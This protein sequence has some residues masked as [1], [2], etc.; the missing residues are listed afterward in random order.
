MEKDKYVPL[1]QLLFGTLTGT[2]IK[3]TTAPFERIKLLNQISGMNTKG[4]TP[5][6]NGFKSFKIIIQEEGFFSL[7]RG[8]LINILR[9]FPNFAFKFFINDGM[10]RIILDYTKNEKLTTFQLMISGSF[11]GFSQSGFI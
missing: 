10:K 6:Y 3:T 7:W 9:V 11:A 8:N 5:K 2:I 1:K 4:I